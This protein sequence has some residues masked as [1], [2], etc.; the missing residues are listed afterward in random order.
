M[1]EAEIARMYRIAQIA[2]AAFEA[3][4]RKI[5]AGMTAGINAR[6]AAASVGKNVRAWLEAALPTLD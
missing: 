3:F 6:A 2:S 5:A 1:S 4:P